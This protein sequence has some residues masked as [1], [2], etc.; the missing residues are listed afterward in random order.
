MAKERSASL[1]KISIDQTLERF[2]IAAVE[3]TQ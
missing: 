1:A 3:T 2:G